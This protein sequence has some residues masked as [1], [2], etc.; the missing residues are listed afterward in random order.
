MEK[1][2]EDNEPNYNIKIKFYEED[3]ELSINSDYNSFIQKICNI[4]QT[5]PEQLNTFELSYHDEDGDYIALTTEEDYKIFVYQVKDKLVNGLIIEKK[6]NPIIKSN[7]NLNKSLNE[8]EK[9]E[10]P[11]I[12]NIYND[13]NNNI[14][15]DNIINNDNNNNEN[16]YMNNNYYEY[17]NNSED[18]N[19]NN[20]ISNKEPN[21][22]DIPIDNLVFYYR[23]S[24]CEEYPIV[25]IIYYCDKCSLYL[26]EKCEKNK[27]NHE[28]PL[29][30]IESKS[31]LVAIKEKENETI[32]LMNKLKEKNE[33]NHENDQHNIQNNN[34]YNKNYDEYDD[35]YYNRYPNCQNNTFRSHIIMNHYKRNL[36]SNYD[37]YNQNNND[38]NYNEPTY[39]QNYYHFINNSYFY[40]NNNCY[41]PYYN[42]HKYI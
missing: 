34:N 5:S 20:L 1:A 3:I 41:Y 26:C 11:N 22:E 33:D 9:N 30:K 24:N 16:N 19:N 7:S 37:N 29:L 35:N 2:Q 36:D 21:K 15:N 17:N 31:Q 38:F 10:Q 13:D 8:K 18:N 27:K 6:D 4:L 28:H 42:Y 39:N 12:Y 32:E 23:C 25:C 40:P 14:N